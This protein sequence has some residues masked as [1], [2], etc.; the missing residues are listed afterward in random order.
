M[1]ALDGSWLVKRESGVLPPFGVGKRIR[2]REGWT[3]LGGVPAA[4]FRVAGTT[5]VYRGWPV[6][7]ELEP[8]A[9]GSWH[10]RGFLLGREFCRFSLVRATGAQPES[11]SAASNE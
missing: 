1:T 6:R 2:G 3:T 5:L 4:P 9:D 10:G 8:Q 7:D 11:T